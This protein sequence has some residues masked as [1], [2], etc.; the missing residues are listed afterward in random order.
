[1][2]TK[3][4][5]KRDWWV[6]HEVIQVRFFYVFARFEYALKT[7]GYLKS[8]ADAEPNW[9]GFAGHLD[10]SL[11][12]EIYSKPEAEILFC[13]PPKKQAVQ[14]A[15]PREMYWKEEK[16]PTNAQELFVAVRRIRNNL[17]HGGKSLAGDMTEA[18]RNR[19]LLEA[20]LCVLEMA[21]E[22]SSLS[23]NDKARQM[24]ILFEDDL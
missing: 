4:L 6:D 20:A 14:G 17:F 5:Q 8:K 11:F 12:K 23:S 13:E 15:D 3:G 1:M 21:L 2:T 22:H 9:D 24:K 10:S 19:R 18:D 7:A 16:A